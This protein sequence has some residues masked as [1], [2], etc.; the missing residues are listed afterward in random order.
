[1]PTIPMSMPKA[2]Q[3]LHSTCTALTEIAVNIGIMAFCIPVNQPLNPNRRMPAVEIFARHFVAVQ[4]PQGQLAQRVLQGEHQQSHARRHDHRPYEHVGAFAEI[5]GA[6][7]LCRES[8]GSHAHERAVPVDEVEDRHPDGQCADR[9]RRIR[10]PVPGDG[11]RH[12]SHQRYG[13]VRNDIRER[14]AQYFAV[15]V[16]R[17]G[18]G[19]SGNPCRTSFT[20]AKIRQKRRICNGPCLLSPNRVCNMP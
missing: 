14:D 18:A 3:R 10:A 8:A 16:H 5:P 6:E 7:R 12:D 19:M 11:R 9:R 1:M 17:C 15:H 2:N 20:G 13:D 4:S